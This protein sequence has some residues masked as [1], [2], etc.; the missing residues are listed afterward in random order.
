MYMYRGYLS[1]LL[2]LGVG[3]NLW[4]GPIDRQRAGELAA[5][6]VR[7]D[8]REEA[9]RSTELGQLGLEPA[10][11]IFNDRDHSG[12][13]I[14]SG[15][16]GMP[17]ILGYSQEG[18]LQANKLPEQLVELLNK[19]E[20]RIKELRR[21]SVG[22]PGE[23]QSIWKHYPKAVVGPLLTCEWNQSAPYND[24]APQ[25][26]G[27][28][29]AP[30]GCVATAM[31]QMMYFH[32]WPI[33]G[34]GKH[35]YT[36]AYYGKL[37]AD[38]EKSTY[39][40][41]NMLDK[42]RANF[43]MPTWEAKAG[44]AVARLMYD[45]AVSVSMQFSPSESG[46]FTH[47]AARAL[48]TNF[49]YHIR[50]LTRSAMNNE[51]FVMGIK[52]ELNS[53]NPIVMTGASN[54][55]GHA[56]VLDGYDENGLIHVN[57]GW[58]GMSNGYFD[59]DFMN[60]PVLGIGGGAGKFNEGQDVI[61]ARPR[62]DEAKLP[63][64][65]HG[66]HSLFGEGMSI[67]IQRSNLDGGVVS[68]SIPEVGNYM[69]PKFKGEF[70]VGL[71]SPDGTLLHPFPSYA[72]GEL[73]RLSYYSVPQTVN[74]YL[75]AEQR[76]LTGRYYFAPI[77]RE[78]RLKSETANRAQEA[79]WEPS[80]EW[81][82]MWHS[83]RVEVVLD[84]GTIRL[85]TDGNTPRFS[86]AN[87]PEVLTQF[88]HGYTGSIRA[89]I[90]NE[91]FVTLS[92]RVS[93]ALESVEQAPALRDTLSTDEV[94]FY[95]YTKVDRP[96]IYSI[97][98]NKALSPGKYR[99]SFCIIKPEEKYTDH[100]GKQHTI[101][102]AVY[103]V[104][105]SFGPFEIDV[106]DTK[107]KPVI[108]Y[109]TSSSSLHGLELFR[110]GARYSSDVIDISDTKQGVWEIGT[111]IR[112]QGLG[113]SIESP[114]RYRLKDMIAGD[115]ID[116]AMSPSL[117]IRNFIISNRQAKATID[118][119][120]VHLTE[121]RYYRILTEV[122]MDG[123]WVDVWRADKPRRYLFVAP[124]DDGSMSEGGDSNGDEPSHPNT[125]AM[126]KIGQIQTILYP[127]PARSIVHLKTNDVARLELYDMVGKRLLIHTS[128]WQT[129]NRVDVSGLAS[130][131][132]LAKMTLS[133]GRVKVERL[134]LL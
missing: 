69:Q 76:D 126:D 125:T 111:S 131:I 107:N 87:A 44:A 121:G 36:N 52:D 12:F 94:V 130:G 1:L 90:K 63:E 50:Y 100:T 116:L 120:K 17:P 55:G 134:V 10:Y 114:V 40:W 14:I 75:T 124:K 104:E 84:K 61:L 57:W 24:L 22:N 60:P 18:L 109:Y 96:L 47:D 108:E 110:D 86:L 74:V 56:W 106:R 20:L 123:E 58:G 38:F 27:E 112:N 67:D 29:R 31:A 129:G 102:R 4:A 98:S 46:A 48:E 11:H 132:Y 9:L 70:G 66:R 45:A 99:V 117:Q 97:S 72:L 119:S 83:N 30:I 127:N 128:L 49:D 8:P 35:T 81:L 77:S 33:S 79:S 2:L 115:Y 85:I 25:K 19:Y 73:N 37:S 6:F 41:A 95:D 65:L 133:D 34:K 59:L 23:S 78:Q 21:G 62:R 64:R 103:S 53:G 91:S 89:V 42:Y 3:L 43:E 28:R 51:D 101:P 26:R 7:L 122:R 118:F 82:P 54:Q 113:A 15:Q 13:V 80:G 71:Y 16:E 32:K 5:K 88:L 105:N 39:D 93:I 68:F 92:G